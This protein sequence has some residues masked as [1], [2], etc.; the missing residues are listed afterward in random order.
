MLCPRKTREWR[1]QK[2]AV[3]LGLAQR[4]EL[5]PP[6]DELS[7]R[8]G[9]RDSRGQCIVV[10]ADIFLAAHIRAIEKLW[11]FRVIILET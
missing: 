7:D 4:L 8:I 3:E 6:R 1:L 10:N 5:I 2:L 11:L 9:R